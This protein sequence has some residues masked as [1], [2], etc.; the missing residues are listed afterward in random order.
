MRHRGADQIILS[1]HAVSSSWD[2]PLAV[3]EAVLA[4]QLTLLCERGYEGLTFS[5]RERRLRS[6]DLP[7]RSVVVTFDDGYESTLKAAPILDSLGLPG[8][9]FPAVAFIES[10]ESLSWPGISHWRG[11][12]HEHE[13]RPLSWNQLAELADAGWEVGSHTFD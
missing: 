9:I 8:T 11:G 4:E 10:G 1:Y 12:E 7:R 3:S 2:S 13:L 5:E 6:G